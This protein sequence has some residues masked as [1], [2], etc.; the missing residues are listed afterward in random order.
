ML[1]SEAAFH[2]NKFASFN[3]ALEW[4]QANCSSFLEKEHSNPEG[5]IKLATDARKPFQFIANIVCLNSFIVPCPLPKM[6]PRQ[7]IKS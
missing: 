7:L 3:K 2:Y 1:Q 6:L 4:I 5:L